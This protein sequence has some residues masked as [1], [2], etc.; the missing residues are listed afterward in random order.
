MN[1][2]GSYLLY[3]ITVV[4]AV[5]HLLLSPAS[6]FSQ[7]QGSDSTRGLLFEEKTRL[8]STPPSCHN[9]CNEC[10]PCMAVQVPTLPSHSGPRLG[11]TAT[12]PME[13][14]ESSPS[15]AANRYSNYKP[16]GWKCH[17]GDHFFN[18]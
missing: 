1:S 17:C 6:C 16:L 14:F 7:Q 12:V 9:K 5:L 11:L 15:T 10:H 4:T 3:T 13:F 18:P 8:G 2:L